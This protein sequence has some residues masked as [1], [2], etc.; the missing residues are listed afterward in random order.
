MTGEKLSVKSIPGICAK[1]C[2]T[3]LALKIA[4]FFSLNT[5]IVPCNLL[6]TET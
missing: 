2:A 6:S 3:S 5:H 4:F 1:P